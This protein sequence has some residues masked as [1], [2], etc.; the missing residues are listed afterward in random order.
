MGLPVV[1]QFC[2]HGYIKEFEMVMW[3]GIFHMAPKENP[4]VYTSGQ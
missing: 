2:I 3:P 4:I 1:K